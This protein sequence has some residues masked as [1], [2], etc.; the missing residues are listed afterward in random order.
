MSIVNKLTPIIVAALCLL[1]WPAAALEQDAASLALVQKIVQAYGGAQQI[2][3]VVS[4]NADGL[5]NAQVRGASG[6]YKRWLQRPRMLRVETSYPATSEARILN[7]DLAWRISDGNLMMGVTGPS[8]LAMIYQYKQLDLPYGLLKGSYNLRYAG[9]ETVG[10]VATEAVEAWDDEGPA[11]RMNVDT[12]NHFIV[13]V[14][15]SIVFGGQTMTLAVEFSDFRP[16]D[17][18]PLPFHINNYAG[19]THI[20]ETIMTRY[21]INP[22]V[23][24]ALFVPHVKGRESAL[25]HADELLAAVNSRVGTTTEP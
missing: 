20:S 24:P 22:A 16:V 15:G 25:S 3:R 10:S 9:A 13:K 4:L 5:I 6:T 18:T 1:S 14:T 23:N 7:G 12:A 2:E 11:I 21:A 19:G 8:R 17:G